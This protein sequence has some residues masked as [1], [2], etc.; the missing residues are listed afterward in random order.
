MAEVAARMWSLTLRSLTLRDTIPE[1]DEDQESQSKVEPEFSRQEEAEH[2]CV[3]LIHLHNASSDIP[4]LNLVESKT[5][6]GA[7]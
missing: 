7:N 5:S 4:K 3:C 2:L 6:C 1:I